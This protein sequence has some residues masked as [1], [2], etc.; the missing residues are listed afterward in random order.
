MY[1]YLTLNTNQTQKIE[2]SPIMRTKTQLHY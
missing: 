2:L 1:N